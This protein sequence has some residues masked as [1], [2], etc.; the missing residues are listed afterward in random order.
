V[1][2]IHYLNGRQA[3]PIHSFQK[4]R[5][6]TTEAVGINFDP[7]LDRERVCTSQPTCISKDSVFIVDLQQLKHPSD[8]LCNDMGTW[9]CNGCRRTWITVDEDG[10]LEFFNKYNPKD[11]EN[12]YKVVRKYYNHK[13]RKALA[14]TDVRTKRG[15]SSKSPHASD[16]S[17]APPPTPSV[18]SVG[19]SAPYANIAGATVS[20]PTLS[21]QHPPP[22]IDTPSQL[23][24]HLPTLQIHS[25]QMKTLSLPCLAPDNSTIPHQHTCNAASS[26]NKHTDTDAASSPNEHTDTDAASSPNEHRH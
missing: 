7:D 18:Y 17:A 12:C 9:V 2:K 20:S 13:G 15:Q 22:V 5:P 11:C 1:K 16:T 4:R 6:S 25:N 10:E 19:I 8:V 26:S 24:V 14:D 21:V 23:P 3:V